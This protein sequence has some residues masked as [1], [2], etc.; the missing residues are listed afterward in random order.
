MRIKFSI[1]GTGGEYHLGVVTDEAQ[2]NLLLEKIDEEDVNLSNSS[3]DGETNVDF[4]EF[5]DI[6]GAYGPDIDDCDFIILEVDEND[7][8]ISEIYSKYDD[9]EKPEVN[10]FTESNP[11]VIPEDLLEKYSEDDLIFG[12]YSIEKNILKSYIIETDDFNPS[13]IFLGGVLMD[14]TFGDERILSCAYYIPDNDLKE[15]V[16]S[17]EGY[18]EFS[19][20]EIKENFSDIYWT[21]SDNDNLE[22]LSKY[23]LEEVDCEGN[24]S[25][26]TFVCV[27]NMD[28]ETL[29]EAG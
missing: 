16:H 20:E 3:E 28:G 29:Y 19:I 11:S 5:S 17:F 25:K 10:M 13:N 6:V 23:L 2:K 18:E 21:I 4:F 15:I 24:E 27:I 14:E 8:E 1:I 12:G 26:S 7:E 22:L 9:S